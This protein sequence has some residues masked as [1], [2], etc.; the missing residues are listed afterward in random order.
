M[1]WVPWES[2]K[3]Q[4]PSFYQRDT[5]ADTFWI[6]NYPYKRLQGYSRTFIKTFN[7]AVLPSP[8]NATFE[9]GSEARALCTQKLRN[10][11]FIVVPNHYY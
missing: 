9:T 6:T 2:S 4:R 11:R 7:I 8:A 1:Q 5:F 3:D 10:L